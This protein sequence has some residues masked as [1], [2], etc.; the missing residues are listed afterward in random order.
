MTVFRLPGTKCKLS[1]LER[2]QTADP[3]CDIFEISIE[4]E[5]GQKDGLCA[6]GYFSTAKNLINNM[7]SKVDEKNAVIV[8]TAP[9]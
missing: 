5:N 3:D 4:Y 7:N 6:G 9:A 8:E 1:L 2:V